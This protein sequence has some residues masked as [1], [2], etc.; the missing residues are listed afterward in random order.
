MAEVTLSSSLRSNLLSLQSTQ[1]LLNQTQLRLATNKKVNSALDNPNSFFASQSLSNRAGD[2]GNLLDGI[3]QSIQVLKAA[4]QGLTSLTTLVKQ[5]QA[6][7]QSAQ[8]RQQDSGLA[9]SGDFSA[10]NAANLTSAVFTANDTITVTTGSTVAGTV[11]ITAGLTLQQLATAFNALTG[12]SAQVVDGSAGAA[13]GSKRLEI[14]ATGG[15]TLTLTNGTGTPITNLQANNAGAGG[16]VGARNDTGGVLA[17]AAAIASTT[18]VT[19]GVSLEKQYN[20]IR[21]Q[22]TS[23]IAD[24]GYQGTNLLNGST[25][26]VQFNENNSSKLSVVGVTFNA[27]GLGLSFT[28]TASATTGTFQNSTNVTATLNDISSALTTLR[29]QA[30]N[31]GTNLSIVQSREDFT[32]QLINT[33]K[34]GSDALTNADT[35]EEGANLLALQTQQQLGIQSL[36]L[37]SQANQSVLRLFN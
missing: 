31:F 17:S 1:S 4:D 9:R 27:T 20:T 37:A 33:L 8:S 30:Q 11:T 25:L 24:T 23:L 22:I 12:V 32:K 26:N 28:A 3:G 16:A 19:D 35:N 29:S 13:A 21:S 34:A 10:A 36:S 7:A 14:R 2:L 15:A 5:A 18:N 6:I